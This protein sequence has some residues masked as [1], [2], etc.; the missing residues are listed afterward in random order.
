MNHMK[1][2]YVNS[3]LHA[4]CLSARLEPRNWRFSRGEPWLLLTPRRLR[5]L[6]E[7]VGLDDPRIQRIVDMTRRH[8]ADPGRFCRSLGIDAPDPDDS[9]A[10]PPVICPRC[11]HVHYPHP[12]DADLPCADCLAHD[13]FLARRRP[14]PGVLADR[15]ADRTARDVLRENDPGSFRNGKLSPNWRI[16]ESRRVERD[17]EDAVQRIAMGLGY[18]RVAEEFHCSVGL[19]H[20]KVMERRHW[21]DN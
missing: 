11:D 1:H 2:L 4:M 3:K 10:H 7:L 12:V 17:W 20:K 9:G 15:T 8:A 6:A 16:N 18:R 5:R 19:L 13:R 21:E 14:S